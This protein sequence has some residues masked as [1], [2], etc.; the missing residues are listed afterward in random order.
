MK[1]GP[2]S[3]TLVKKLAYAA[4]SD[5]YTV[6]FSKRRK[7]SS[8]CIYHTAPCLKKAKAP[9][10]YSINTLLLLVYCSMWAFLL[11]YFFVSLF[12]SSFSL[13]CFLFSKP[14]SYKI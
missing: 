2:L 10:F 4:L 3:K 12:I 14:N 9:S 7:N 13:F 5:K 6:F 1:L 8:L 11:R